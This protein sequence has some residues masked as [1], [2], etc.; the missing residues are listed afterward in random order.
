MA[1]FYARYQDPFSSG[2]SS[3]VSSIN[4]LTGAITLSA[5][6]N[7]TITPSGNTLTIA[8]SGGGSVTSVALAAPS[9]IFTVSGSPITTSGTLTLSLANQSANIVF[10]GPASGSA[11]APTFRTLVSA[12]IPSLTGTYANVALS[13]LS[14]TSINT[15]LLPASNIGTMSIG[16]NSLQ[17]VDGFFGHSVVTPVLSSTVSLSGSRLSLS[18][19]AMFN[20]DGSTS[21]AWGSRQLQDSGGLNQL[22]WGSAVQLPQLT[23][24]TALALNSSNAI[25]SSITTA[26]ELAFVHGVTSAIQT[27]LNSK[28]STSGGTIIGSLIV[29]T[30]LTVDGQ[31]YC[32][33]GTNHTPSG[34][35]QTISWDDGNTQTLNLSSATGTVTVTLTNGNTGGYYTLVVVQGATPQNITLTGVKW[36]GGTAPI[37]STGSGDT[38]VLTLLCISSGNF[39]GVFSQNFS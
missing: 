28:L 18:T 29:D 4:S 3:G 36:P 7:I 6:S 39:L 26:A 24:S 34:T 1:G 14:T 22:T 15:S 38:D 10:S 13:N 21:I 8:S 11:A 35:T 31:G 23:A 27:Q 5:G 12:D 25:V 16:S 30:N 33:L 19:A 2:S 20:S 32:A 17:W 9:S 37:I